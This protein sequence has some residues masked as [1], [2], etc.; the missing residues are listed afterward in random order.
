MKELLEYRKN[1]I[2]RL[3][4]VAIE[5]REICLAS[6]DPFS[7]L[8]TNGWNSHQV[9]V[10]TRDVNKFVYG[11][12]ARETANQENPVFQNFD[13]D[14]HMKE[15]YDPSESLKDVLDGFVTDIEDL[16]NF[17]SKLPPEAWARKSHHVTFGGGFT[18]QAW[19]ERNL[20]HIEEHLNELRK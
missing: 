12:R 19:V 17:L 5:F 16:A 20:A 6:T 2:E 11:M 9:A 15:N 13:G 14:M 7:P 18:P 1:L 4:T 8:S 10:H 3:K